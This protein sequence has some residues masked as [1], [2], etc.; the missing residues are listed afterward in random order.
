[1]D[2][3]SCNHPPFSTARRIKPTRRSLSGVFAFRGEAVSFESL[4]ERDFLHRMDFDR[5]V[6]AVASQPV[7]LDF[8]ASNGRSYSYTPD[9]LVYFTERSGIRPMLVEV[10][11]EE[12]WR[13]NWR[14]WLPKWK[15]AWRYASEQGWGF[16]IYDESRIRG[17]P[18]QN[19]Q[20]IERFKRADYSE[21]DSDAVIRTVAEMGTAPFHYLLARHFTGFEHQGASHLFHLIANRHLDCD[22]DQPFDEFLELWVTA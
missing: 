16:H 13:E 22:I 20:Y 7:K 17:L 4:L 19:I 21:E 5:S 18:L 12:E 14:S 3:N 11:L 10:K 15:A 1:M 2:K 8:V 6:V 9:Y